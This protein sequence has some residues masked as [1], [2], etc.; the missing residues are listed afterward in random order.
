LFSL[1]QSQ[2]P[3]WEYFVGIVC[4]LVIN[5]IISFNEENNAGDVDAARMARLALKTKVCINKKI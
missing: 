2:G 1:V 4:L 5:S 3:F